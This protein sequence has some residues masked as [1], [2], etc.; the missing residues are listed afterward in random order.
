MSGRGF[1][2]TLSCA[3]FA[4][5]LGAAAQGI[6]IDGSTATSIG[7]VA[8]GGTR[9]TI[10]P[11]DAGGT[12]TNRYRDFN[13]GTD[14]VKLDNR[15]A[16]AKLILNEVTGGLPSKIEGR[17]EVEGAKA[18]L[19]LANPNGISVNGGSVVNTGRALLTTGR[20]DGSAGGLPRYQIEAGQV[21]IGAGGLSTDASEFFIY[22]PK[23]QVDGAVSGAG[24]LDLNG[25]PGTLTAG[26][27]GLFGWLNFT[28]GAR[29]GMVTVS[30]GAA[31]S[32][33]TIRMHAGGTGGVVTQNGVTMA[34]AGNFSISAT[35]KISFGGRTEAQ[36]T[37][38]ADGGSIEVRGTATTPAE[39]K[40]TTEAVQLISRGGIASEH[41]KI[42]AAGRGFF[43]FATNA[44]ISF[45]AADDIALSFGTFTAATSDIEAISES[46]VAFQNVTATATD[47]VIL[48]AKTTARVVDSHLTAQERAL[49]ESTAGDLTV[50]R[51]DIT[52]RLGTRLIG[53]DVTVESSP[54]LRSKIISDIGGV[55]ISARGTATNRGSLIQG[56]NASRGDA[57]SFGGVSVTTGGDLVN[58]TVS[59]TS[60][61]SLFSNGSQLWLD[62]GGTLENRSGR[63]LSEGD[64]TIK[65]GAAVKNL[66][67]ETGETFAGLGLPGGPANFGD[68]A[69]GKEIGQ[70]TTTGDLSITAPTVLN[71]GGDIAGKTVKITA[72]VFE[73]RPERFGFQSFKRSCFLFF[74]RSS[75]SS[76]ISHD[77][78]SIQATETLTITAANYAL[79]TGGRLVGETGVTLTSPDIKLTGN[80]HHEFFTRKGGLSALFR[81]S[82][83]Q[84][85]ASFQPGT[86]AAPSGRLTFSSA[87]P[88]ISEATT[89]TGRDPH[90]APG[91]L[92]ILS[93]DDTLAAQNRR[94][95]GFF[96]F[97]LSGRK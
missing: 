96:R 84:R 35:G 75:G 41:A 17:L 42:D 80:L 73:N 5:P 47:D 7:A 13:V 63:L 16:G 53:G 58:E 2:S 61:A 11:T 51:S 31:L 69:I 20:R 94:K 65:A 44:A 18:D 76:S 90:H 66:V 52:S 70:V 3:V 71:F 91:G 50:T 34:T 85:M 14:G 25:G 27:T 21:T 36:K 33:G 22:A 88:A 77:G 8:G 38:F 87:K 89:L 24:S 79:N 97:L 56:V 95:I 57:L 6:T 64:A 12:S 26:S 74:C 15:T 28:P 48:T 37:L 83:V 82:Q 9:V 1:I 59:E 4:L 81:A 54:T 29:A 43:G 93:F 62:V 67:L 10:A 92:T 23:V 78:G 46:G 55:S 19:V 72:D 40:S 45:R 60:L 39:I 32:G 68:Y 49:L 86:V 30:S